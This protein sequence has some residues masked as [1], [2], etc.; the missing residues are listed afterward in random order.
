MSGI[1]RNRFSFEFDSF[2]AADSEFILEDDVDP[3]KQ[4]KFELGGITTGTTITLTVPDASGTLMVSGDAL[5]DD[6]NDVNITTVADGEVLTY[7]TATSKWINAAGGGGGSGGKLNKEYAY[8]PNLS[9]A[10]FAPGMS[11]A[12][13]KDYLGTSSSTVTLTDGTVANS[14][15]WPVTLGQDFTLSGLAIYTK[16]FQVD[17]KC[18]W[19]LY[20]S[21]ATNLY[22]V[23]QLAYLGEYN[24]TGTEVDATWEEMI[25]GQ[26]EVL[27]AGTLYWIICLPFADGLGHYIQFRGSPSKYMTTSLPTPVLASN[28]S[29]GGMTG[30][31][32]AASYAAGFPDPYVTGMSFVYGNL[33]IPALQLIGTY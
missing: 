20:S 30:A 3:T 31:G 24:R 13:F 23:D 19:Y 21:H 9:S 10:Y 6:L 1:A 14:Y 5:I 17:T 26:S 25:S 8:N 32:V 18:K 2:S 22:P 4:T 11:F 33:T 7:D 16:I 29:V 27:T 12:E 28:I 15:A